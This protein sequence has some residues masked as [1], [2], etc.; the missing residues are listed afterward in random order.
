MDSWDEEWESI[1][2]ATDGSDAPLSYEQQ[3][4][5]F[6]DQLEPGR[7]TYNVPVAL[8][9]RGV[10]DVAA[11]EA[12]IT[13]VAARHDILRTR[14]VTSAD[15][16]RLVPANIPIH[17]QPID[18]AVTPDSEAR[19]TTGLKRKRAGRSISAPA[20]LFRAS[21]VK[22]A[23]H[24]RLLVIVFHHIVVDG[25]SIG[26][27][28]RELAASYSAR[29]DGTAVRASGAADSVRRLR[30]LAAPL[31]R[32]RR[33]RPIA[34]LLDQATRRIRAAR[35]SDRSPAFGAADVQRRLRIL[36]ADAIA[37]RLAAR[38]PVAARARRCS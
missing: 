26:I 21:L 38:P 2:H 15:E 10:V 35:V 3:R 23:E 22:I 25:W 36:S 1:P 11:L 34:E 9:L 6:L 19:A 33:P 4:L 8:R 7:A 29:V 28:C 31:A 5:W 18:F 14:V 32:G 37:H 16:Q 30:R 20:R 27:F 17:L 13:D 24:D 12:G